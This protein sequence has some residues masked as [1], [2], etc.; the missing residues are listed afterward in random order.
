MGLVQE[1]GIDAGPDH[2]RRHEGVVALVLLGLSPKAV[3]R[4]I[5]IPDP[6]ALDR[7]AW[8]RTGFP[9]GF[10]GQLEQDFGWE[11]VVGEMEF[12]QLAHDLV[13]VLICLQAEQSHA[14]DVRVIRVGWAGPACH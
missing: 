5:A 6:L 1:V 9:D 7:F 12:G 13:E 8:R 11:C 3:L 2:G 14:D 4:E 10:G